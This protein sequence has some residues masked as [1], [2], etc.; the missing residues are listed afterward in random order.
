GLPG[1]AGALARRRR[2]ATRAAELLPWRELRATGAARGRERRTTVLAELRACTVFRL[3]LR[4]LHSK[5]PAGRSTSDRK[6]GPRLAPI[7]RA[8]KNCWVP[9]G[10]KCRHTSRKR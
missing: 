7:S 8:I 5:P 10:A 3:A 1:G 6:A 4:A 2:R 9:G